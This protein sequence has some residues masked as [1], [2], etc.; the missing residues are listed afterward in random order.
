LIT[1]GLKDPGGTTNG[2]LAG[3]KIAPVLPMKF[4][5]IYIDSFTNTG[6]D[7]VLLQ[8]LLRLNAGARIFKSTIRGPLFLNKNT[9]LGPE[10]SIGKYSGMNEDCFAARGTIGAFCAIGARNAINPFNHPTDWL[11]IHEFQ[12]HPQSY[13]WVDEY[14]NLERLTR[15]PDMFAR[16]SIGNDVWTGHNVNVLPGVTVGDGAVI[17][18]GAVVTKDVPP[19]AI[20]AGVPAVIKKYRFSPTTIER[21]LRLRWWELELSE[22]NGLPFRDIERCLDRLEEIRSRRQPAAE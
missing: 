7:G 22:L 12:Y 17:A 8:G 3:P 9:Q 1:V 2:S 14:K 19:Y 4:D 18:A 11:S 16:V 15:T 10:M 20:V 6:S 5:E 13:D 21:L